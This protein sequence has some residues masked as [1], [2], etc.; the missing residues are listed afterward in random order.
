MG[1]CGKKEPAP[2]NDSIAEDDVDVLMMSWPEQREFRQ[3][4]PD[5]YQSW[6][7]AL[8]KE[9]GP[10]FDEELVLPEYL[11]P[12]PPQIKVTGVAGFFAFWDEIME[13]VKEGNGWIG[14]VGFQ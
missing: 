13:V 10:W 4:H 7:K 1:R 6:V 14:Q 8:K 9:M 11:S 2:V 5:A 12:L 3:R